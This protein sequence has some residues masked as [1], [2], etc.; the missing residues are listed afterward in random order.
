MADPILM[1]SRDEL[2]RQM[3]REKAGSPAA[4][5]VLAQSLDALYASLAAQEKDAE[6]LNAM[7][8]I[9]SAWIVP[10]TEMGAWIVRTDDSSNEEEES[11]F[12]YSYREALSAAI[13]RHILSVEACA[14]WRGE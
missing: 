4:H 5:I 10:T 3:A 2:E 11:V 12:Y 9:G 14:R 8:R 13:S 7:E 1:P 6:L